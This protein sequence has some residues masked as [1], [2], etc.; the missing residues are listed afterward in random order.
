MNV[1]MLIILKIAAIPAL[2]FICNGDFEAYPIL[3]GYQTT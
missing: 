3:A 2:S 1:I